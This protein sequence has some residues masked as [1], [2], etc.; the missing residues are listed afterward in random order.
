MSARRTGLIMMTLAWVLGGALLALLFSRSIEQRENP[1]ASPTSVTRDG[2]VEVQL[3]A[4]RQGHFVAT[5]LLN[6]EPI[7]FL[8]DT[9]AT[10]VVVSADFAARAGLRRGRAARART[11]NGVI[12]V[13]DTRADISL[14]DIR[15]RDVEASI[16]PNMQGDSALLGMSFLGQLEM[17]QRGGG[18]VL[19]QQV[20]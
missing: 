7:I 16:N 13:F 6:G 15:L 5:G 20:E 18:L 11:A 1:N 17:I 3:T 4:N 14:G 12:T 8:L 19:R 2:F 10:D 9:G